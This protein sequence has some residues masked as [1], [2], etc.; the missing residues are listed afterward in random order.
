MSDAPR[1]NLKGGAW[2]LADL[3]LNIWSLSLVKWLGADYPASQVVF[4][5]AFVGLLVIMP[6]IWTRRAAAR[7]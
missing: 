1:D 3:S 7:T 6:L 4:F 5:R 2:L